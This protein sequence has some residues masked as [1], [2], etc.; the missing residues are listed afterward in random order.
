YI[1]LLTPPWRSGHGRRITRAGSRQHSLPVGRPT[2]SCIQTEDG[3]RPAG[4]RPGL[5]HRPNRWP[6]MD[7]VPL[8]S[9]GVG[10]DRRVA[11]GAYIA[12]AAGYRAVHQARQP[13]AG[14]LHSGA[15]G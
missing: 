15:Y 13:W 8:Q 9:L 14:I 1:Y 6:A 2:G 5:D 11:A 12:A 3:Q 4:A 10:I 7:A